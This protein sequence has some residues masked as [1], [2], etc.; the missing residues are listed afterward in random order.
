MCAGN[1]RLFF[2]PFLFV[3]LSFSHFSLLRLSL[4]L[5]HSLSLNSLCGPGRPPVLGLKCPPLANFFLFKHWE[6]DPL[7]CLTSPEQIK[8]SPQPPESTFK[9]TDFLGLTTKCSA[10]ILLWSSNI[11]I[12]K[13]DFKCSRKW[14]H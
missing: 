14:S 6:W 12:V 13:H 2:L 8:S 3:F 5:H 11:L 9:G 4:S 7:A 1:A 10:L